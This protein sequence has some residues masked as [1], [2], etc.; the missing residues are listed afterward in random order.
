[1]A[2]LRA[3][4]HALAQRADALP[5]AIVAGLVGGIQVQTSRFKH[6]VRVVLLEVRSAAAHGINPAEPA[7]A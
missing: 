4:A 5:S 1:M 7:A 2:L 6:T 3:A